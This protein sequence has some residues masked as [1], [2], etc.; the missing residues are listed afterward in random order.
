MTRDM[1]AKVYGVNKDDK[2]NTLYLR[3]LLGVM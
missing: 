2:N 3:K 1:N